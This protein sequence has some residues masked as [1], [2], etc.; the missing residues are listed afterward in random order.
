[1]TLFIGDDIVDLYPNAQVF[2]TVQRQNI[3]NLS[4]RSVSFSNN[5][6][7]PWTEKNE[8]LFGFARNENSSTLVT[9][10]LRSC[11]MVQNG[12]E[13]RDNVLYITKSEDR[14]FTLQIFENIF[15]WF[16]AVNEKNLSD[17]L[18]IADSGWQADDIDAARLNTDGIVSAL[19][20]WGVPIYDADL[21]LPSFYYYSLVNAVL[22]FTGLEIVGSILTDAR[23]TDLIVPYPGDKFEYPESYFSSFARFSGTG[24]HPVTNL[25]NDIEV[26]APLIM[27][28]FTHGT[29][30]GRVAVG[31]ISWG[32]GTE[33][34]ARIYKNA[35]QIADALIASSPAPG[36]IGEVFFTDFISP[37]DNFTLFVYSNA[38]SA[39][40][41]DF[42]IV[43]GSSYIRFTPDGVVNRD[44]VNWN[45]LLPEIKCKD[46]L[47]D[48][49]NRFAIIP[50]QVEGQLILK[51]LEEIIADIA[52]A[53][54]WSG[55]LVNPKKKLIGFATDYAQEN[56]FKYSDLVD[57]PEL[58][59]GSISIS[60]KTLK[61]N[62][63]IFQSI[64]G[65]S[66]TTDYLSW[67]LAVIPVY[68]ATSTGI[69][70]FKETP[71]LRLLTLKNYVDEGEITFDAIARDDYK[72]GYFKDPDLDKDTEFAY[73]VS[74][75][76]PSLTAA[77]QRN[78]VITKF[79]R[80][81]EDDVFNFDPHK[82]MYDGDGYYL[83][84]KIVNYKS[85]RITKVELFKIL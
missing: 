61:L 12:K 71:G 76:Y 8:R 3:G 82:M 42:T 18:P 40:G 48:F 46:L 84:N 39:P 45:V 77:L 69:T 73:F 54:D 62:K 30:F 17:I 26:V 37:G 55:K 23:F 31:G 29:F 22:E 35:V 16:N 11:K 2:Y 28:D 10:S 32:T 41:I 83:I 36:G 19:I 24:N 72:I 52:G 79:Y 51:T 50:K 9:Y 34:R 85:E 47:S 60:N 15:E 44:L 13:S 66:N 33:L 38:M 49:F 4:A 43:G 80:L 63:T 58:G 57:D 75:F 53:V 25:I 64:F 5:F 27:T 67:N 56:K 78:K 59:A 20:N 68:D 65:N 81:G 21:F 14:K 7:A 74:E 70:D 6:P 1:M